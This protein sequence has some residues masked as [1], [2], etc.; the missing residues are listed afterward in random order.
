MM[1][2]GQVKYPENRAMELSE[3]KA[4]DYIA[5]NDYN[6]PV[7]LMMENAGLQLAKLVARSAD[8]S[9]T[10]LIGI[11]NGNNGGGGLV[12]ARRL[13]AWVSLQQSI[14]NL[15]WIPCPSTQTTY[16]N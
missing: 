7:E 1:E 4:M 15:T 5:V 8:K 10:I 11:G 9:Q 14:K 3:F 16:F 2:S 6:L 12:A 13:L